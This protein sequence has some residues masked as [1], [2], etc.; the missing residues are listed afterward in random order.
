MRG[1]IISQ[2]Q[3]TYLVSGDD[4]KRYQ[5]ATWDWSGK[6][7][8]NIGDAV[9]FVCEGDAVNSVFPLLKQQPEQLKVML[10]LICWFAGIFGVHRF[11]VG[12]F[13]TGI[14]MLILS[15]SVVGLVISGIW[16]I[17]DFIVIVAGRFSKKNGDKI[18]N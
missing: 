4:G 12:K 11:M 9:D 1:V 15:L 7:P 18:T 6:N 14:L 2:D 10:A 13:W 16:A 5:F 3:G 17:I 8:P